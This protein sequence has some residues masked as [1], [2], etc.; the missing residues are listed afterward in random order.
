[1]MI[2]YKQLKIKKMIYIK[3]IK[4]EIIEELKKQIKLIEDIY[5]KYE[6]I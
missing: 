3:N 6:K 4:N 5:L 1:M 2:I